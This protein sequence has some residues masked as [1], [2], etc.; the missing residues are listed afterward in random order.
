VQLSAHRSIL[1]CNAR[2]RSA[3]AIAVAA[4]VAAAAAA[5]AM[6]EVELCNNTLASLFHC[7][8]ESVFYLPR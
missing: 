4:V 8:A 7:V 6:F 2:Q 5:A 3:K 1:I